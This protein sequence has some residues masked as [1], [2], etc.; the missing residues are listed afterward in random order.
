M[1]SY[2]KYNEEDVFVM[3]T[4]HVSNGTSAL[5]LLDKDGGS[6]ARATV[7]L[8]LD[9]VKDNTVWIKDYAENEGILKTLI[10]NDIVVVIGKAVRHFNT[11]DVIFYE[12]QVIDEDVLKQLDEARERIKK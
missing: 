10:E 7:N 11:H 2:M 5:M 12:A 1:K 6:V 9:D 3:G 8:N 4:L